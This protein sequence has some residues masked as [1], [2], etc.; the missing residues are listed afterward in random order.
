M[1]DKFHALTF[2]DSVRKAQAHYYGTSHCVD[3]APGRDALTDEET[4][5][6]QSRDSFYMATGD[7][8]KARRYY[9]HN[10]LTEWQANFYE[11]VS[12]SLLPR[13]TFAFA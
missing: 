11:S 1:A 13:L 2:T 12:F 4:G 7:G 10:R 5:L 3:D 8:P 9:T 6:I